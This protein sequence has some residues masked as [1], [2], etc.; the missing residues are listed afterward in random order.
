M[1]HA[2]I[3]TARARRRG[4]FSRRRDTL[5]RRRRALA[6]PIAALVTALALVCSLALAP[7]AALASGGCSL[8]LRAEYG[9]RAVGEMSFSLWK[10][11]EWDGRGGLVLDDAWAGSGVSLGGLQAASDWRAAAQ[12]LAEFAAR[13]DLGRDARVATDADG[14]VVFG[15]LGEEL[16]LV[17]ADD[18]A[19][20]SGTYSCAPL[21]VSIP[22][23]G[24]DDVVIE[25]KVGF[26]EAGGKDGE[27]SGGRDAGTDAA[28][29]AGDGSR[30]GSGP[31]SRTGDA[32]VPAAVVGC[33][34][35]AGGALVL[36]S[37]RPRAEAAEATVAGPVD[38]APAEPGSIEAAETAPADPGAANLDDADSGSDRC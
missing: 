29:V 1:T 38:T 3:V 19:A 9:G 6:A 17:V 20:G 13:S 28:A 12:G 31:L 7:L 10:V 15:G 16:Y 25:P 14:E 5:D 26:A 36:A 18:L 35:V 24:S 8:T 30:S 22:S 2:Q 23:S 34:L 11:G 33:A 4:D 21:L 27:T 32:T 37:R